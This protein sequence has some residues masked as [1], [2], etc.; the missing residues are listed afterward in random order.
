MKAVV[1][2]IVTVLFVEGLNM[3]KHKL[4]YG[5]SCC[6][7]KTP[8]VERIPDEQSLWLHTIRN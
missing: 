2:L 5:A 1:A 8:V 3:L 7:E 6:G 4:R